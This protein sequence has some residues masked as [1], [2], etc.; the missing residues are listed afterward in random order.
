[1]EIL[2]FSNKK[3]PIGRPFVVI[4]T[5]YGYCEINSDS[6][7]KGENYSI[8]S[9]VYKEEYLTNQIRERFPENLKK[10]EIVKYKNKEDVSVKTKYGICKTTSFSLISGIVPTIKA[11]IDK[12]EYFINQAKEVHEDKYDYSEL[13]YT[14]TENK[15]TIK[16]KQHNTFKQCPNNHLNGQGCPECGIIKRIIKSTRTQEQ[17]IEKAS[18]IHNNKYD[19]SLVEYKNSR[20]KVKIICPIHKVFEQSPE[21]HLRGQS[22]KECGLES[23]IEYSKNN[24]TGWSKTNWFKAAERSKDFTGFKVYV[25]KCWNEEEEFFKI[26]RS[27]KEV[28]IRFKSKYEMPYNYEII[29]IFTFKIINK[30][31]CIKAYDLETKLKQENKERK[32][33]PKKKFRGVNECFSKIEY[34]E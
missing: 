18:E 15:I 7:I 16:C 22:C 33:I 9:A 34:Y 5:K 13:E 27:F 11:A 30:E 19:Y 3:S 31:N 23:L 21:C 14:G 25:L 24:P 17:F 28:K 6:I 12:T 20:C 4:N 8:K 10:Y 2:Y 26:G 32:Y 29:K 1:M